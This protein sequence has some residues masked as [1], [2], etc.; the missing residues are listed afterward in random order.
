M[1]LRGVSPTREDGGLCHS[2]SP[3]YVSTAGLE[4]PRPPTPSPTR[5]SW[6]FQGEGVSTLPSAPASRTSPHTAQRLFP[7]CRSQ[8]EPCLG[9]L[10]VLI[11]QVLSRIIIILQKHDFND[12]AIFCRMD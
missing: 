8:K 4:G 2:D 11:S 1:G 10:V 12:C 7:S 9:P 5:G 3:V 6:P